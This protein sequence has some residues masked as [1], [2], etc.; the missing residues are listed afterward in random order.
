LLKRDNLQI[1]EVDVWDSLIKWGIEQTPGLRS[2]NSEGSKWN[3]KNHKALKK[4][5]GQFI[6]L[7][8]FLDIS[9]ADFYCKV[10]PHRDVIP[11]RIYEEIEKFHYVNVLPETTLPPRSGKIQIE[12]KIITPNLARSI[13]NWIE[14]KDEN[15]FLLYNHKYKF[16]L[17]YRG[18]RDEFDHA[19][20]RERCDGHGPCLVLVKKSTK[21]YG[22]YNH[23]ISYVAMDNGKVQV[24][25]LYFPL[26]M[27]MIPQV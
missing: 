14:R 16:E 20:F 18:S 9:R 19:A 2:G 1:E 4:T 10:L 7:I 25:V 15:S 12:S 11:K 5:L 17:L 8:Q 27:I 22:G 24:K 13:A 6:P 3:N 23:L 26:K 21:I